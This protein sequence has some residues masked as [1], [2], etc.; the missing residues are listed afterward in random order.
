MKNNGLMMNTKLYEEHKTD[1][2]GWLMHNISLLH[3][4]KFSEVDMDHITEELIDMGGSIRGELGSR[5]TTLLCHLLKWKYQP[6]LR[7]NSW[8]RTLIEQRL[9][10]A[11]LIEK[12]PSL[13]PVIPQ[14]VEEAYEDALKLATLETGIEKK[15]FP[16]VCPFTFEQCLD[17]DFFPEEESLE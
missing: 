2:Y 14:E 1:Y 6:R 9:R 5:L 12:N 17:E 13:K 7:G 3:Q 4:K 10:I 15:K 8:K 11:R 16:A